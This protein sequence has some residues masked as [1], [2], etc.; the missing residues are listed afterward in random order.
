MS[1]S[2]ARINLEKTNYS[3][4]D[5]TDIIDYYPR[6]PQDLDNIYYKYCNHHAFNSVMPLFPIEYEENTI[7]GYY[8]TNHDGLYDDY[9]NHGDSKIMVGFSMIC[10]FDNENAEAYQF[11]WDY[12]RPKLHL[13]LASLRHE[14]AYYKEKGFKYLYIGGAD[15]YKQKIDG[16]EIMSPAAWIDGRW[17]IDGFEPV[18]NK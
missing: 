11:A 13:G 9:H 17:T 8:D 6:M 2:Y 7:H 10:E 5:N 4:I 3:K 14:C 12:R 1:Y 16:F 15:E 18:Q